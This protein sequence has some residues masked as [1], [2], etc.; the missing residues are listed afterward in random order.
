VSQS[1]KIPYSSKK[2]DPSPPFPAGYV[3]YRPFLRVELVIPATGK[4]FATIALADT[5]ADDCTFP[6]TF[7]GPLALDKATMPMRKTGGL[8]AGEN[9]TFYVETQVRL[10]L[11]TGVESFTTL[12][13]FTDGMDK[14]G[15]GILGQRGF[16]ETFSVIFDGKNHEFRLQKH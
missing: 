13:G 5:G 8:G 16:F 6:L 10:L 15:H 4:R 7:L 2:V 11:P 14:F 3:A 12:V 9:E 1:H